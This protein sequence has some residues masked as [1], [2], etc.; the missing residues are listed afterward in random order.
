MEGGHC[1]PIPPI[2][3]CVER[4]LPKTL[5]LRPLQ[6]STSPVILGEQSDRRI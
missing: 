1:L 3:W 2:T 4:I 5:N 6:K